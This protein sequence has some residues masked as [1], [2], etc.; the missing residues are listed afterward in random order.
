MNKQGKLILKAADINNIK[1]DSVLVF[2]F[3]SCENDEMMP[4]SKNWPKF[5]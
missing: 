4:L 2:I 5:H 3:D 1:V